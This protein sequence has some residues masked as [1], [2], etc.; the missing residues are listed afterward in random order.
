MS[1]KH[2]SLTFSVNNQKKVKEPQILKIKKMKY[3]KTLALIA[4]I[5]PFTSGIG[6]SQEANID[7][8]KIALNGYSP[9]SYIELNLAQ[10]GSIAH[11]SEY[12]GLKYYFTDKKQKAKFDEN[13]EQYLPQFGKAIA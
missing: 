6:F 10:R 8:S 9:V 4:L 7:D 5:I 11:K 1:S 3:L 12:K 2:G 13:P